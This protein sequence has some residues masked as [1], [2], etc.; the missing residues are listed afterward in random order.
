MWLIDYSKM[1][2]LLSD[3][4]HLKPLAMGD[5]FECTKDG[6]KALI[7]LKRALSLSPCLGLSDHSKPFHLFVS[8]NNGYMST[9]LTQTVVR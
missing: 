1:V 2:Q 4:I 7:R 5:Q 3:L 6:E 8:E 9:I